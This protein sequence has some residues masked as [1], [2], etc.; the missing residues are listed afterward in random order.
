MLRF[1]TPMLVPLVLELSLEFRDMLSVKNERALSATRLRHQLNWVEKGTFFTPTWGCVRWDGDNYRSNGNHTSHLTTLL[2]QN[3]EGTIDAVSEKILREFLRLTPDSLPQ[4]PKGIMVSRE[5]GYAEEHDDLLTAFLR[6]DNKNSVRSAKDLRNIY[7]GEQIDLQGL[8]QEL[9]GKALSGVLGAIKSGATDKI[10]S[11]AI[12]REMQISNGA[13]LRIPL[14]RQAVRWIVENVEEKILYEKSAGAQ[15]FAEV[16]FEHGPDFAGILVEQ[17]MILKQD[18]KSPAA[19]WVGKLGRVF[20][21]MTSESLITSG[22]K[23]FQQLSRK[24]RGGAA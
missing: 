8:S 7:I 15:V 22:R 23:V 13:A 17:F 12:R 21:S 5:Q 1:D 9:V 11:K 10:D 6:Y 16:F 20:G 24:R 19:I 4:L 14:V 18:E 2:L 3:L